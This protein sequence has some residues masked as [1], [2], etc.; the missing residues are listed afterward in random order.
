MPA[1]KDPEMAEYVRVVV[2]LIEQRSV[3]LE[4]IWEMLLRVLR[5]RSMGRGRKIDHAVAWLNANPP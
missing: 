3:S 1:A 5:Q 4:E 2:S